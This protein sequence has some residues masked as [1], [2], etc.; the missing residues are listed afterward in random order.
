MDKK[1]MYGTFSAVSILIVIAVLIFV[2]LIFEKINIQT[3]LTK[4]G[5]YTIT[6]DSKEALG[7]IS[8]D[9]NIY[10]IAE[11]GQEDERVRELLDE[12]TK[13]SSKIS[14]QYINPY[15]N[16]EFVKGF[17]EN[18]EEIENGS[19]IVKNDKKFKVIKPMELYERQAN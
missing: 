9:V 15:T 17:S 12:Y 10:V 6:D 14:V 2:N 8:E 19:I 5:L 7:K 3:D 16:P 4:E 1:L 18:G 13:N 11:T